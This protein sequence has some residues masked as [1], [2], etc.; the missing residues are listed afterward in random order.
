M[1]TLKV[2]GHLNPWAPRRRWLDP[3]IS[4]DTTMCSLHRGATMASQS[5]ALIRPR[6][7]SDLR[8][9]RHAGWTK[10]QQAKINDYVSQFSLF[11]NEDRT[12]LRAPRF[13]GT[14]HYQCAEPDCGGH[15]QGFI[16]WEFVAVQ[17]LRLRGMDDDTAAEHLRR[18]FL[19]EICG[20]S[21]DVAFY[22]GNVT[23]HPRTF[24]VLGVYYPPRAKQC[25]Q[26]S[27]LAGQRRSSSKQRPRQACER[28][29]AIAA[30]R[31]TGVCSFQRRD[32]G[33]PRSERVDRTNEC[34]CLTTA[35]RTCRQT[36]P[37]PSAHSALSTCRSNPSTA[38][39]GCG[40]R[41]RQSTA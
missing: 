22:V 21:H 28:Q 3:A 32:Q 41:P 9:T 34:G 37:G 16:D 8:I 4:T 25:G 13:A 24:S 14:Y 38:P 31:G 33:Q 30:A 17:L 29:R 39:L 1:H 12:P 7:I 5:L 27:N 11:D 36:T 10:E 23:A 18:R 35:S 2:T 15:K 19:D 6:R 26:H 40:R 20:S